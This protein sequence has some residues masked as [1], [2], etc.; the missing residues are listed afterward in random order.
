MMNLV[1]PLDDSAFS[2]SVFAYVERFFGPRG[3]RVALLNVAPWP[4]VNA[5]SLALG[6][7]AGLGAV[8]AELASWGRAHAP[9]AAPAEGPPGGYPSQHVEARRQSLADR[10]EADA[11]SLREVGYGVTTAVRFG[12]AVAAEIA[13]FVE[14]SRADAVAMTTHG[15]TTLG[16]L[17]RGSVA[18]S[19]LHGLRAPLLLVRAGAPAPAYA[20]V[21]VVRRRTGA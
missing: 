8:P 3:W 9:S 5:P 15:R 1:I 20:R 11:R 18:E 21:P 13:R 10:L 14:E 19:L 6:E 7:G 16:R 4:H 2:R 17:F 12:E